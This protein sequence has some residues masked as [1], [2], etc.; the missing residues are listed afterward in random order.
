MIDTSKKKKTV[1]EAVSEAYADANA[2]KASEPP[3]TD[4]AS[5]S[6]ADVLD[7][8]IPATP[9]Y[10]DI[11]AQV[12]TLVELAQ[13]AERADVAHRAC[14][15]KATRQLRDKRAMRY[16]LARHSFGEW[17]EKLLA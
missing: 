7:L 4:A 2:A 5:V 6:I 11:L 17:L 10:L 1:T 12:D 13:Q 15:T 8:V 3:R 14:P 9:D 16:G